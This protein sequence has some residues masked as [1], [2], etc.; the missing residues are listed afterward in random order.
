MSSDISYGLLVMVASFLGLFRPDEQLFPRVRAGGGLAELLDGALGLAGQVGRHLHLDG[1]E[2]RAVGTVLATNALAGHAERT[3]VRRTRRDPHGHWRT[4]VRRHLDLRPE[5]QLGER[6]RHGHREVVPRSAEHRVRLHMHPDEQVAGR[7]AALA[8][9]ALALELDALA[10]RDPGGD[11]RLDDA[12]AHRP[13]AAR[14]IG[15]G[16]VHDEPAAVAL[17]A[18]LGDPERALALALQ[19]GALARRADAW[20]RTRLGAGSPAGRARPLAGQPQRDGG[21][22]DRV[23]ERERGLGLH[24]LPAARPVRRRA[25]LPVA[26]HA[27]EDVAEAT[28]GVP[29]P[30]EDVAKVEAAEAALSWPGSGRDPEPA[31]K[32]GAG[33][34]VLLAA[35]LVGE[36]RVRLGDLLELRLCRG[37]ALV[38]V[39]VVLASELAVRGLDISLLGGLGDPQRLVVVL[40]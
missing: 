10:V 28:A 26:E 40:L 24:V 33:L 17:V 37:V 12:R 23:A 38:R 16:V 21:A 34:V 36:H 39:G 18:R 9:R 35:L 7:T 14:A 5:R 31:A 15:A 25:A 2:Q 27:A 3:A 32:Q 4:A 30:G 11:P 29:G 6:D 13:P 8:R 20:H 19:A 22:V 1:D